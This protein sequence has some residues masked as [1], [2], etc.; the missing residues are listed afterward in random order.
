MTRRL[1]LSLLVILLDLGLAGAVRAEEAD[2]YGPAPPSRAL[3]LA[4]SV[5]YAIH[6]TNNNLVGMTI[7]NYGF[8]GNNFI[9]R[10]PSF[11]YPL[12]KGFDHLV[13][14]G[15]WIGAEAVDDQ[16]SFTGVSTAAVDGVAG[17][18]ATAGTEYTP[19]SLDIR[20]RSSLTNSPVYSADAVSEEDLIGFYSDEPARQFSP[21]NHRP[22]NLV[23]RQMNYDWSFAD[24]AHMVFF[25]YVITNQGLPLRNVY[26]GL[27]AELASGDKK[28]CS[29]FP[30][31]ATV[32]TDGSWFKKKWVEYDDSLRL[33]R[34]HYCYNMPLPT[35]SAP[36]GGCQLYKV[37][38]WAGYKLLGAKAGADTNSVLADTSYDVTMAA[39]QYSPADTS[40]RL[41]IQRYGIMGTGQTQDLSGAPFQPY[42]GDPCELLTIGPFKEIDPGDSI[43]VDFAFVGG[44]GQGDPAEIQKHAKVAQRAYD[45]NYVVPV[46]PPSPRMKVIARDHA[47]EL[48]WDDSPESFED[49]TSFPNLKDF[50]GYR[51]Y[52]GD[53][54]NR[55]TLNLLAQYDLGTVPHDTTGFNT[56]FDSLKVGGP[57]TIDNRTYQY[58]YVIT[59]L[60][61]GFR[62]FAAVTAYDLG[63]SEIQSLESGKTQNKTMAVPGPAAGEAAAQIGDKVIV[64]PNPYRVEARWDMGQ[65]VRDHYLWFTNLPK[66]CHLRIYTLS[67]DLVFDTDFDGSTYAGNG[68]RGVY[69][70]TQELDVKAPTLSGT[71][72]AWNMITNQGQAAATGLYLYSIEDLTGGRKT[73]VGKFLIVK[74]DREE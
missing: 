36:D 41:D 18:A 65:K 53:E 13:R 8:I 17:S 2:H 4:D 34:E 16:G 6:A 49:K 7:T 32:C 10:A 25:H 57:W 63:T 42:N 11:E 33:F 22:L 24:Y 20:E 59:G 12:G 27:Y 40:R 48:Y 64:F 60:R 9:S 68:A 71:T 52:L 3:G 69:N 26:V 54:S 74:S 61:D 47:L 66:R 28:Q 50:E 19:A 21:E 73:A 15:L 44:A 31:S 37:P 14:G 70:P 23:V 39:W 58:R 45:L 62:Y 35:P 30:P 67:G 43:S 5:R 1:L 38:H 29:S 72:Y 55:D 51:V 56:G 46:P